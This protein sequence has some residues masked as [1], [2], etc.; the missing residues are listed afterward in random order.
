[1]PQQPDNSLA[2]FERRQP[3]YLLLILGI[4]VV[5][6]LALGLITSFRLHDWT[7]LGLFFGALG[8]FVIAALINSSRNRRLAAAEDR[9]YISWDSAS[10]ELQ[11]QNVVVEVRELAR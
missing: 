11:R 2:R 7:A 1:M 4:L 9:R 6:C 3:N 10:P 8:A 5:V